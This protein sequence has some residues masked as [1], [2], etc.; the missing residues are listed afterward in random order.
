MSSFIGMEDWMFSSRYQV[1]A[2]LL[3]RGAYGSVRPAEDRVL[4]RQVAVKKIS[5]LF[6]DLCD[7]KRILR[8]ISIM[9]KVKHDNI[10]K[11]YDVIIPGDTD[12]FTRI[13]IVMELCDTDLKKLLRL[14]ALLTPLHVN[15]LLYNLLVGL[16]YLHSAGIYH[17]DLKPANCLANEDCS[18][19]ICDFGLAR[20]VAFEVG[21]LRPSFEEE[22]TAIPEPA[23]PPAAQPLQRH[24]TEHVATRH[25]RAP[26]LILLQGNYTEA[27]DMWSVGCIYGELM[28]MLE[29]M[30]PSDREPLFPGA[31][32][33]PLT[34]NPRHQ[35]DGRYHTRQRED[36]LNVIFDVLGTP[37]A[38]DVAALTRED[39]QRYLSLF[40]QRQGAGLKSKLP[41]VDDH[42]LEF[43][44]SMLQFSPAKR[45]T[46]DEAIQHHLLAEVRN[47]EKETV[48]DKPIAL[49]FEQEPGLDEVQLRACFKE[50][51][52]NLVRE[53]DA[54]VG[55][56]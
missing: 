47:V 32:C 18:V 13:F 42:L 9:S 7:S 54:A 14:D 53:K 41:R 12:D 20:D 30:E 6:E 39:S 44:S 19:K 23:P 25:Y 28:G 51:I 45:I 2:E 17:R 16:K 33:F 55:G 34:P 48:A 37:S 29:G 8:E 36:Q 52:L 49:P 43:L 21:E 40:E 10:V 15:T 35:G 38:E 1:Q 26:E 11:L 56:A 46:V 5:G 50:A 31:S 22:T 27:I 24:L 4:G 3:G